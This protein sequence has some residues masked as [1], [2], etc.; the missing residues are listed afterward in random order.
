MSWKYFLP[1]NFN[2]ARKDQDSWKGYLKVNLRNLQSL[3]Q[4]FLKD[5]ENILASNECLCGLN[6]NGSK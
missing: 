2:S 3:K 4:H 1:N 5:K 6:A